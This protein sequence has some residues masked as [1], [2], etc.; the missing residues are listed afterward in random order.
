M[1]HVHGT[2]SKKVEG[3]MITKHFG[4]NFVCFL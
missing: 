4:I 1:L 3:E 2:N